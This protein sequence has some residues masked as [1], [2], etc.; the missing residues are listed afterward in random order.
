ML[1]PVSGAK[2]FTT[3]DDSSESEESITSELPTNERP[4]SLEDN[5][6]SKLNTFRNDGMSR[7]EAVQM[8][9]S[10]LNVPKNPVYKIALTM[11]WETKK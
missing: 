10:L 4:A 1:G 5:I 3:N 11:N 8:V 6:I 9:V 2:D 7:K